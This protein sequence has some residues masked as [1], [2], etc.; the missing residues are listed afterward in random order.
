MISK[1]IGNSKLSTL[2]L[3]GIEKKAL[4]ERR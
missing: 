1:R 4:Q 2:K 3:V